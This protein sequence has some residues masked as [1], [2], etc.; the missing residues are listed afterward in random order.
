ML[1]LMYIAVSL[2][3]GTWLFLKTAFFIEV[4][5]PYSIQAKSPSWG[6]PLGF[7]NF[8]LPLGYEKIPAD[9]WVNTVIMN[10]S[11]WCLNLAHL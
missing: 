10:V 2:L 4:C 1:Q 3:W 9:K 7:G 11:T 8:L 5:Q 6:C